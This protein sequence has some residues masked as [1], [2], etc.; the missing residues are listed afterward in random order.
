MVVRPRSTTW[1][2]SAGRTTGRSIA[3]SGSRW[4]TASRRSAGR[5][6][7]LSTT[8]ERRDRLAARGHDRAARRGERRRLAGDLF[9]PPPARVAQSK[10]I[11]IVGAGPAGLPPVVLLYLDR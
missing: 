10:T 1:F 9:Q 8:G 2:C 4:W 7:R 11:G 6:G 5:T 3:G